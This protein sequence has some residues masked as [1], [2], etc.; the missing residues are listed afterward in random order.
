MDTQNQ[1][2]N[3]G[4]WIP[5]TDWKELPEG[6]WIVKID[7]DRKPYHIADVFVNKDTKSRIIIVGGNFYFDMGKILA[8]SSFNTYEEEKG[9]K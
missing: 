1:P 3:Q 4:E 7:K 8:Y 2:L 9:E 5:C 6:V